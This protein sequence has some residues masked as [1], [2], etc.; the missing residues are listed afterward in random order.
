MAE[1]QDIATAPRDGQYD[2]D[3]FYD[4]GFTGRVADCR[5]V[6]DDWHTRGHKGWEA[7]TPALYMQP[8]YWMPLPPPPE[9]KP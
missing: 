8:T 5:F 6:R 1:W 3:L 9:T 7:L 4:D 2:I